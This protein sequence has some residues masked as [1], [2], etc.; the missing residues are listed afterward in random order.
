MEVLGMFQIG[1][2]AEIA[3][4]THRLLRHY[5][6]VGV[7]APAETDGRTGYRYYARAQV[8]TLQRVLAYRDAGVPLAVVAHLL[9]DSAP[10]GLLERQRDALVSARAALDRKL[11]LLDAE[12]QRLATRPFRVKWTAPA[13]AAS[14][15]RSVPTYAEA[16]ALLRELKAAF[17]AQEATPSAAIWHS[18]RPDL[19]RIDCEVQVVFRHERRGLRAMPPQLV[20]SFAHTGSDDE[21][22]LIYREMKRWTRAARY[23]ACGP[24]REVYWSGVDGPPITEV[25]FPVSPMGRTGRSRTPRRAVSAAPGL[26]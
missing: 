23:S 13:W 3:G 10:S 14:V 19:G 4:V 26:L 16:D 15:R 1:E 17:A 7:L 11:E 5:E 18:C 22:P 9:R 8:A 20:V 25:Q 6:A 2:F 21:L 12:I 24:L